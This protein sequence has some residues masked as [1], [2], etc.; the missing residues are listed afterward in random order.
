MIDLEASRQEY[1]HHKSNSCHVPRPFSPSTPKMRNE[2][3]FKRQVLLNYG[4]IPG[5]GLTNP[6]T[7]VQSRDQLGSSLVTPNNSSAPSKLLDQTINSNSSPV[8]EAESVKII[9]KNAIVVDEKVIKLKTNEI[10]FAS[11]YNR[12][13]TH[14]VPSRKSSRKKITI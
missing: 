8:K 13:T 4:K 2:E 1:T 3:F 11:T 12:T 7:I 10:N 5:K 6:G 14:K 9:K